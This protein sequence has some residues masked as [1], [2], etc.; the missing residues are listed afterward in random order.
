MKVGTLVKWR[1]HSGWGGGGQGIIVGEKPGVPKPD[2]ADSSEYK[3]HWFDGMSS[4]CWYGYEDFQESIE[5]M[6]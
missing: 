6:S 2:E 5:V 3:I 4:N 1:A